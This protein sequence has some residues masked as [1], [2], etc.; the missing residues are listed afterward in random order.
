MLR[1]RQIRKSALEKQAALWSAV[2]CHSFGLRRLDAA[3][4]S[5]DSYLRLSRQ[6]ANGQSAD[7][8]AHSKE[9]IGA[10][11]LKAEATL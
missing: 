11:K 1:R 2:T 3:S 8:S 9:A 4:P 5:L 10:P 7:W 6:V